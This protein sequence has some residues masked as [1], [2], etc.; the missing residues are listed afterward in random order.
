MNFTKEDE[1]HIAAIVLTTMQSERERLRA[2]R[3]EDD[4]KRERSKTNHVYLITFAGNHI[5]LP[6]PDGR[7]VHST[8]VYARVEMAEN[9]YGFYSAKKALVIAHGDGKKLKEPIEMILTGAQITCMAKV[10]DDFL[11]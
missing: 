5:A 7:A 6:E 3:L 9:E 11:G 2:Q 8:C 10:A 4:A 1:E